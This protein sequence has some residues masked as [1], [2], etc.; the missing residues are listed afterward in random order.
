M[1]K[2]TGP[3]IAEHVIAQEAAVF[4]AATRLFAANGVENVAMGAIADEVGLARSSLYRYF[5][6]KSAIVHRWFERAM[7]PLIEDSERIARSELA[8]GVRLVSWIERQIDFLADPGNHAMIRAAIETGELTDEQRASISE[9]HRA[10]Y[11]SLA[12]IIAGVD[13]V[14][15]VTTRTRAL[16]IVGMLRNHAAVVAAGVPDAVLRPELIRAGALIAAID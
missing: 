5:P 1:P 12:A 13:L 3:T 8:Q 6:T 4:A 11:D 7:A 10:L 2:I 15:D 9:R 16:L 14:V